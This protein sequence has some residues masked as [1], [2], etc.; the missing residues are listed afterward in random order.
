MTTPGL[1]IDLSLL[2]AMAGLRRIF[3]KEY[4]VSVSIGVH[5]FERAAPQRV[6][7]NVDVWVDGTPPASDDIAAVLDYDAIRD[8]IAAL[9]AG[10]H[11]ELQETLADAV[12]ALCLA[13]P[14]VRAARVSTEKPD[15]YPDCAGVGLEVFAFAGGTPPAG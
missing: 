12:L 6:L 8:G 9:V 2:L 1:P 15:V 5:D 7:V 10:R 4:A 14:G 3:L 13:Q 11:F